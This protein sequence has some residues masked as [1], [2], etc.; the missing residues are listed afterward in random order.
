MS[1]M[2]SAPI[3]ERY[4]DGMWIA[5]IGDEET[6]AIHAVTGGF[7]LWHRDDDGDTYIGSAVTVDA[8]M[9]DARTWIGDDEPAVTA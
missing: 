9:R 5:E 6:L 8:A 1:V 3:W 2:T 4:G 7:E